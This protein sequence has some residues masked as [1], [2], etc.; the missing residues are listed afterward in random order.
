[1]AIFVP[2]KNIDSNLSFGQLINNIKNEYIDPELKQRKIKSFGSAGIEIFNNG[3]H[4]IYLD[5]EIQITI[6]FKNKK[7]KPSD[8]GKQIKID[9]YD[10]KN[11]KWV[12]KRLD[13]NSVKILIIHFNKDWWIYYADFKKNKNLEKKFMATQTFKVRGG[14]YMPLNIRKEE[15]AE[16]FKGY[17]IGLENEL[18][19]MWQRHITVSQKYRGVMVYDGNYFDLFSHAQELYILGYYYSSIIICRCS[20]EQALIRILTKVGQGFEIYKQTQGKRKLKSIE[21]LVATCRS[22][23]LFKNKYPITKVAAKKLNKI[24][25]IASQLVHPKNDIT[26]LEKYKKTAIQCMDNLQD[27]IK[28]HLNFVKDTG[29]VH[30]YKFSGSTKRLK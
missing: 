17:M 28:K 26:E 15:K 16:F 24:S 6:E 11:L 13:T 7:F 18:P 1:M 30:G 22:Y 3:M 20:A 9:L 25:K 12:D 5:N 8:Q 2:Q 14:G 29:V 23:S 27:V 19:K 4:K 21:Q 10:I